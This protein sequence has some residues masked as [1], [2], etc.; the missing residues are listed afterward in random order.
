MPCI[1]LF[2]TYTAVS[3]LCLQAAKVICSES[4]QKYMLSAL[5]SL[6]SGVIMGLT[7]LLTQWGGWIKRKKALRKTDT[8]E[9]KDANMA[10]C[11]PCS[12]LTLLSFPE[13]CF[14]WMDKEGT[15][16]INR[17]SNSTF[18]ALQFNYHELTL[19]TALT[20]QHIQ[21]AQEKQLT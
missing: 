3:N 13:R 16:F 4:L 11:T 12:Q 9:G 14:Y 2:L 7:G 8:F 21:C 10:K 1:L 15:G 20:F 6:Q 19:K 5:P 17:L 18:Q